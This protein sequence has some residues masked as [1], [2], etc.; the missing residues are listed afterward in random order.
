VE[1]EWDEAKR[2]ANVEKHGIDFVRA[3]QVFDGR[4]RLDRE[5]PRGGENRT[6]SIASLESRIIAVVWTWR[7]YNTVRIISARRA[8]NGEK[9]A[10]QK[11]HG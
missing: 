11:V 10:Y 8:R 6:L 3:A 4:L 5:A 2:L 9:R 7:G 1:F